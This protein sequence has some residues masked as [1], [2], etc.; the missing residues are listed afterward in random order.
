M[1]QQAQLRDGNL[2]LFFFYETPIY[3]IIT[4][5]LQITYIVAF[6]GLNIEMMTKSA[7]YVESSSCFA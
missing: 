3:N 5:S 4:F 7:Q 1:E 6:F 2:P